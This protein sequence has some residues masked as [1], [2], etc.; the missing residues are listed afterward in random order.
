MNGEHKQIE[1]LLSEVDVKKI[2]NLSII[3][4]VDHGKSTLTDNLLAEAGMISEELAGTQLVTDY[5]QMEKQRGI[6]INS[7]NVSFAYKGHLFNITDSPGH[8]DFNSAVVKSLR[9]SDG[10][11]LVV[12]VVEGVMTQTETVLGQALKEGLEL[13]LFINKLDR[14]VSQLY[15]S[16]KEIFE[17]LCK[18][19]NSIND[20]I[21]RLTN[22]SNYFDLNKNVL[23]GSALNKWAVSIPELMARKSNFGEIVESIKNKESLNKKYPLAKLIL[24]TCISQIPSPE[25]LQKNKI[26]KTYVV[27]DLEDQFDTLSEDLLKCDPK[28]A[29]RAVVTE[30]THDKYAGNLATIRVLSGTYKKGDPLYSNVNSYLAPIKTPIRLLLAYIRKY[31]EI[32]QCYAGT[33]VVLQGTEGL[34][35]G[36]S[37]TSDQTD[38]FNYPGLTYARNS[39][40]A[41]AISPKKST[42]MVKMIDAVKTL[43]LEDPTLQY[44]YAQETK[45]F[46]I[47]GVGLLHLEIAIAKLKT[48]HNVEVTHSNPVVE[49]S[50]TL[51]LECSPKV[52]VRTANKHND[53]EF[54]I[55]KLPETLTEKLLKNEVTNKNLRAECEAQGISKDL[56]KKSVK[57]LTN[58]CVY[59]D[60]TKGCSLMEETKQN[61]VRSMELALSTGFKLK[62]AFKGLGFV[63]TFASIHMDGL[64]RGINQLRGAFRKGIEQLFSMNP[65]LVVEPIMRLEIETPYKYISDIQTDIE[66][67]RGLIELIDASEIEGYTKLI[68]SCPL[69]QCFDLSTVLMSITEG[70]VLFDMNLKCYDPV[71]LEVLKILNLSNT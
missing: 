45:E 12:D 10:A 47:Y 1:K 9:G 29:F 6:T 71:P 49:Y 48:L 8:V 52:S 63:I 37:L 39:V 50:E 40:V 34:V 51:S 66:S 44:E 55:F 62:R 57:I 67:R 59:F 16:S 31:E 68:G 46:K 7:S 35:V 13:V 64:H 32:P 25:L 4:H 26:H 58:G 56:S 3:A 69:A 33:I 42:D 60:D 27:N 61:L 36:S 5:L 15:L 41:Y 53:F 2:R 70:R 11:I 38:Q 23:F 24:D 18:T 43:S 22:Q 17:K 54:Y 19:L 20:L 14:V 65:P 30:I 21:K 28:G